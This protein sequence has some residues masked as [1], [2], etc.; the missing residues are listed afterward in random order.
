MGDGNTHNRLHTP[1]SYAPAVTSL[2]NTIIHSLIRAYI[3]NDEFLIET[4]AQKIHFYFK[5]KQLLKILNPSLAWNNSKP[6]SACFI[7][8]HRV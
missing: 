1:A 6:Y 8:V 4:G 3:K 2:T 7:N 5:R